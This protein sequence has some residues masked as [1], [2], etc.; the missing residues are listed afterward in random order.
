MELLSGMD[1]E[2]LVR[3]FGPLEPARVIYLL[4]QVCDSLADAHG[5]GLLHRDIKPA[6]IVLSRAGQQCDFI[7]VLDFGLVKSLHAEPGENERTGRVDAIG[8]PSVMAPE[9][10]RGQPQDHRADLYGLGCVGYWLLTGEQVFAADSALAMA[11]AHAKDTPEPP[12]RRSELQVPPELD[13]IILDC[14]AKDP[15]RR[16]SGANE[17]EE[18]L[19]ACSCPDAW[20]PQKA[21]AWWD[22][23]LPG[24]D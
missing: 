15:A 17:L 3:R 23:H 4:R 24:L 10:V 19:A 14:L 13:G 12:S 1:L 6:N 9:A 11:A 21:R 16:P 8:T 7:K 18:R 2:A 22:I 5:H 20:N